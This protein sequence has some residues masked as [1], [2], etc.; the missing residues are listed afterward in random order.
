[1]IN[2]NISVKYKKLIIYILSYISLFFLIS[3]K[4]NKR[5]AIIASLLILLLIIFMENLFMLSTCSVC[6]DCDG[7]CNVCNP[8]KTTTVENFDNNAIENSGVVGNINNTINDNNIN[9]SEE[10]KD[11]FG[12]GGMFYDENPF[13]NRY[14]REKTLKDKIEND[15]DDLID[16]RNR[17]MREKEQIEKTKMELNEMAESTAGWV[18]PYQQSGEKAYIQ[19]LSANKRRIEGNLDNELP[20]SDYNHLPVASGY[21][22]HDYEYGYSFLPPE[23]WYPT[24][25]RPPVCV[26]EKRSPVMPV[27]T[28]GTPVDAKEFH[29]SRRITPPD[30]INVDYIN[31]KLNS[32]R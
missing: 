1:M 7:G 17:E 4:A 25:P 11:R 18:K 31:D 15:R 6:G 23:K 13:Y 27:Y 26:T 5:T 30:M 19:E 8:K 22:S 32:G 2:I 21:R 10:N 12:F 28:Q 14:E 20:Y 3:M 16:A 24:P 9:V 29:S